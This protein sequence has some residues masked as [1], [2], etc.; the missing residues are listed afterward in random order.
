MSSIY[1]YLPNLY[2]F[3][4]VALAQAHLLVGRKGEK[5]PNREGESSSPWLLRACRSPSCCSSSSP[6]SLQ[7]PPSGGRLGPGSLTSAATSQPSR[8]ARLTCRSRLSS[9]WSELDLS[10]D[11][12]VCVP[13]HSQGRFGLGL[14]IWGQVVW[15]LPQ[16]GHRRPRFMR[17]GWIAKWVN[18]TRHPLYLLRG[19]LGAQP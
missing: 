14:M 17:W 11:S 15:T 10:W 19:S 5:A 2:F 8:G 13:S 6:C 16:L 7:P 12:G 9:Y 18:W 3:L 1:A 4:P